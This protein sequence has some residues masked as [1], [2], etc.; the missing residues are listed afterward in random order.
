MTQVYVKR[1]N[2]NI[3]SKPSDNSKYGGSILRILQK[4]QSLNLH[5]FFAKDPHYGVD[6][7]GWNDVDKKYMNLM[8]KFVRL[9]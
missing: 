4:E 7:I 6:N 5:W 9:G 8:H 1:S 3:S 2:L